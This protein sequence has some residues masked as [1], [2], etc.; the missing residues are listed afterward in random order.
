ME[1]RHKFSYTIAILLVLPMIPAL[2]CSEPPPPPP[3]VQESETTLEVPDVELPSD[4]G[5]DPE[6]TPAE[7]GN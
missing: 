5:S 2:G 3:E 1:R 6:G 4:D 7:E